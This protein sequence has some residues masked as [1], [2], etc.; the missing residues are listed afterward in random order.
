MSFLNLPMSFAAM[1]GIGASIGRS[2]ARNAV[3]TPFQR[4]HSFDGALGD[5]D[6]GWDLIAREH[7]VRASGARILHLFG[8]VLRFDGEPVPGAVVEIRQADMNG[9]WPD[10]NAAKRDFRGGGRAV[11]DFEGRYQFRTILP[12]CLASRTAHIAAQVTPVE[13]R[14]LSTQL[15]LM[16]HPG[17]E[18]D[19]DYQALGP[20]RQAAVSLDPI[21]RADGDLDAGFNFVL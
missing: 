15:Y 10:P 2:N 5:A 20:S 19:W 8:E 21:E 17:N 6:A 3:M 14:K 12:V 9:R 11:T 1:I 13:G 7:R 18:T 16:D 4:Q